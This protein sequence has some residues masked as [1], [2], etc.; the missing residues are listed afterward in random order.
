MQN[1]EVDE[2]QN[3]INIA[4]RNINDFRYVGDIFL[5]EESEEKL[6]SLLMK[7]KEESGKAGLKS[8]STN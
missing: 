4:G 7:L 8:T 3:G 1:P 5:M 6:K 2:F